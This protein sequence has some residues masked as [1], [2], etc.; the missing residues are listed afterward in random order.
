MHRW[1]RG[2]LL[3]QASTFAR[4]SR[5]WPSVHGIPRWLPALMYIPA[6]AKTLPREGASALVSTSTLHAN[7]NVPCSC[8][9]H[10]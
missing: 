10:C 4:F 1:L 9:V 5:D 8:K 3:W 2:R 7:I 6:K